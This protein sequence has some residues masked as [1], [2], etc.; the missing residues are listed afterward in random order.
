MTTVTHLVSSVINFVLNPLAGTSPTTPAQPPLIWG[1]L[2]FA[3]KEFDNFFGALANDASASSTPVQQQLTSFALA[4]A[5]NPIPPRPAFPTPGQQ[6]SPSTNFVDWV[7]GNFLPNNTYQRF[8]VW[9]T[10]VGTMWD[11]GIPDNPSGIVD[12]PSN[13]YE[14]HQILTAAG[15][16]FSGPNMT[17]N[18]M[19]NT[20]FRSSDANLA[21]GMSI[22]NGEW[23]NGN[24]FGGAP[25]SSPTTARQI[26]LQ[27][28]LPAGLP[29]GVT[30][31]PT[32]GIS[33]PTP[34]TEFGATQY[35]SFMSVKQW[36]SPGSWT[37]NYSGIAYSTD[38]GENW[39]I[40]PSSIRKNSPYSG[41]KNFQQAA[42]VTGNDGYV[43]AYGTPNGRQGAAYLSRVLPQNILDASKYQYYSAGTKSWLGT[44]PAGWYTNA[45]SKAT[46][47]FGKQAGAFGVA[48]PGN[49]V[50]EMSVQYNKYLGKYVVMYTDQFNNVV[51]R[52]SDSP[53][54]AWST[55]TTI[56]TQQ[57]GGIY[58]P[59]MNPWSP[60]T[61]G[62]GSDLYW[63][64]S[65][66]STYDIMEMHTDLS[67]VKV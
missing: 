24:M 52:T 2:A 40:A 64:L 29:A 5:A 14:V 58:A 30:L 35:L 61:A 19:S 16:T 25:L 6:L 50:S 53:R 46:P 26:I 37:T 32:A 57:S 62:T 8:G 23:F 27:N 22:A 59:M 13:P 9:G 63:N 4:A 15:D 12:N 44:T 47:V 55:A 3:R 17:G 31:V 10:D 36:G 20:L 42:F 21:D 28:K 45:P 60:S 67:Q 33:V 1:L 38:N 56:L 11:N 34:A 54:G 39:Q 18:W 41:N 65:L 49:T 51:I 43:Y 66:Y 7:T 48:N